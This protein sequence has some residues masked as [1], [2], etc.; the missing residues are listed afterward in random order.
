MD[1]DVEKCKA[2]L[3]EGSK[4][5]D[6]ASRI[7]P[8]RIR[9]PASVFYAFCRV[10]DDAVDDTQA[11][12]DAVEALRARLDRVYRQDPDDDAVDRALSRVVTEHQ[13]PQPLF[14]ALLEGFAWDAE[15]RVYEDISGV[16]DYSARVASAVGVVMTLIMGVRDANAIAR[17]CEMGGA[18]QL[19]NIARDVGEDAGRGRLYLPRAWMA[20]EGLAADDFVAQPN[21]TDNVGRVIERLLDEADRLYFKADAGVPF[22]P[23]DCRPSIRAARLIYSDI[24]RVIRGHQFDSLSRRAYVSKPRKLWLLARAYLGGPPREGAVLPPEPEF[25]FLVEAVSPAG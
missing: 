2:I 16:L 23:K 14:D 19:T 7:L 3:R 24:G 15:E 12:A 21:F 8:P 4:S 11:P 22:L 1:A 13:I 10:A 20:E 6:A 25:R 17:A 5:F 9:D 18:M